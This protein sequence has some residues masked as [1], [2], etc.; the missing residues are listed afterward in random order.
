MSEEM[1]ETIKNLRTSTNKKGK[2]LFKE[3][4]IKTI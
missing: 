3:L 4:G 1:F 2:E